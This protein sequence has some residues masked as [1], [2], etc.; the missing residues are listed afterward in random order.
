MSSSLLVTDS[1]NFKLSVVTSLKLQ[2]RKQRRRRRRRRRMMTIIR[3]SD[4]E[5]GDSRD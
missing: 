1:S 5:G 2:I 3:Q 4:A